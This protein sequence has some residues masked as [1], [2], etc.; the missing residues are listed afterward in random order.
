MKNGS[1]KIKIIKGN[2]TK[3][4][5]IDAI[6]NPANQTL[7]GGGG[8][9]GIIHTLA[10]PDLLKECQKLDGCQ[11]GEAKITS[12]YKLKTKFI[13]HTVGPAFG[14]ED[15]QEEAILTS[16]YFN[17]LSIATEHKLK[18]IAFPSIATGCFR[19]PK[20]RAG[21]IALNTIKKYFKENK[22]YFKEII[23]VLYTELDYKIYKKL[24]RNNYISIKSLANNK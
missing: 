11:K 14:F 24:K 5:Q 20:D 2:I 6:V 13:I 12:G 10:G 3:L 17:C 1:P 4:K 23:F 7:L 21:E 16:C 22:H 9:D 19:F 15:G 18:N 8:L